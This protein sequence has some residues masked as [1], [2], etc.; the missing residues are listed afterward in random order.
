M[1]LP[2]YQQWQVWQVWWVYE[3]KKL[4]QVVRESRPA[5]LISDSKQCS[6][7]AELTFAEITSTKRVIP[8]MLALESG[9]P[10][11]K[12]TGLDNTC[13]A[14]LG[15]VKNVPKKLGTDLTRDGYIRCRGILGQD[16]A[17]RALE[18][19]MDVIKRMRG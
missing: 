18:A 12:Q 11:F 3:D 6:S 17:V 14:Y 1:L 5:L 19:A 15:S 10:E 7:D 13:Y 8:G 2:D 4:K 9:D 16:T